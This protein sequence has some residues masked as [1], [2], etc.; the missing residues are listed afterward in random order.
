MQIKLWT[1][2]SIDYIAFSYPVTVTNE[3]L[4]L[5]NQV[6]GVI[7]QTVNDE[8]WRHGRITRKLRIRGEQASVTKL[9]FD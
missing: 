7:H 4:Q 3:H 2:R 1:H 5:R 9:Y 8:T 6:S